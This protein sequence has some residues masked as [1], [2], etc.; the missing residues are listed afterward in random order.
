MNQNELECINYIKN[1][2]EFEY[3]FYLLISQFKPSLPLMGHA[4]L[5]FLSMRNDVKFNYFLES[6]EPEDFKEDNIKLVMEVKKCFISGNIEHL[7]QLAEG[8][9]P[10]LFGR[11]INALKSEIDEEVSSIETSAQETDCDINTIISDC[12]FCAMNYSKY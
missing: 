10:D 8:R 3:K 1:P 11:L 7:K 4:L 6:L 9:N 12:V 5:N 2:Q